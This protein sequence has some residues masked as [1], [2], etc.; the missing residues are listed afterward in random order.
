MASALA[1]GFLVGLPIA[2]APG[3]IFLLTLR[4]T[5]IRGWRNGL[6]SGLGVATGDA[7]YAS[8]AAFGVGTITNILLQQRRWIGLAGRIAIALIG[9]QIMLSRD[10]PHPNPSPEGEGTWRADPPRRAAKGVIGAYGSMVA[11]TLGNPPTILSF[12]AVFMGLGSRVGS[13]W[14]PAIGL[15][16]GVMLGSAVWWVALTAAA[17]IL[18]KRLTPDITRGIGIVAGLALIGFGMVAAGSALSS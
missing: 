3:P 18:R 7:I 4:R 17:S 5:L 14:L 11:L 8:L 15:V 2:A 13:G 12:I 6:V 10:G 1:L 16:V 9:I